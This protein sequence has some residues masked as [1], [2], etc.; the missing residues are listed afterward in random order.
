MP[1][2]RR[3]ARPSLNGMSFDG[4]LNKARLYE[5]VRDA[6]KHERSEGKAPDLSRFT[7][8]LAHELRTPPPEERWAVGSLA[9]KGSVVTMPSSRKTGKTTFLGNLGYCGLTGSQF[10]GRFETFLD[11]AKSI[12]VVNAEMNTDDC[13]DIWRDLIP[14]APVR[15]N[16]P[17]VA[18]P[19]EWVYFL[20]C[21]EYG[22]RLDLLNDVTAERFTE[23][24]RDREAQWLF[25]DPWRNFLSWSGIG[26]SDG[27]GV[28]RLANRV[29]E[30]HED[31]DLSLTVI[32]VHTP[33]AV[34]EEGYERAKGAGELEDAA[35]SMWRYTRLGSGRDSPRF[36]AV[37]GRGRG[38]G[39][40][41]TEVLFNG[42]TGSLKLGERSRADIKADASDKAA[43]ERVLSILSEGP[44][45]KDEC[46]KSQGNSN[47]NVRAF[48]RLMEAG[49]IAEAGKVGRKQLWKIV[50]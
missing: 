8:S 7:S 1:P 37:E 31:A 49:R 43:D 22:L 12:A 32:P 41:A 40:E 16:A 23:W 50:Q 15:R 34:A 4:E 19:Y 30:I 11:P 45:G 14:P 36:L 39:L 2:V 24:L 25:L 13:L 18:D 26:I 44:M 21:R 46:C 20:H 38:C 29:R 48:N 3:G 33:Q 5:Q 47:A 9:T 27:D 17:P 35:D 42:L 6:L 28:S 10:L